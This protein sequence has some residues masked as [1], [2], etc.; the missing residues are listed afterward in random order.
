MLEGGSLFERYSNLVRAGGTNQLQRMPPSIEDGYIRPD[1]RGQAELFAYARAVAAQ[2]RFHALSGQP[3]GDWARLF[4]PLLDAGDRITPQSLA[5]LT[6]RDDLPPQLVLFF[7]FF[8]AFQRIRDDINTLPARHFAHFCDDILGLSRLGPVADR[9]HVIF[10]PAPNAGPLRLEVGTRLDAGQDG[11]GRPLGY[12]LEREMIVNQGK[13]TRV[14]RQVVQRDRQ[15]RLRLFRAE[16]MPKEGWPTFGADPFRTPDAMIETDPGFAIADPVLRLA[17]GR[18]DVSIVARLAAVPDLRDEILSAQVALAFTG[19]EGWLAPESAAVSVIITIAGPELRISAT[20]GAGQPAVIDHDPAIHT[21]PASPASPWPV[22]RCLV[23]SASGRAEVFS[24]L[25]VTNVAISVNVAGV[26]DLIVQNDQRVLAAGGPLQL[27]T[28]RPKI[29]ST[30][31]VGSTEVFAKRLTRLTLNFDWKSLPDS[32]LQHYNEYFDIH[33]AVLTALLV[34]SFTAVIDILDQRSWAHR[35]TGP[36]EPIH[37]FDGNLAARSETYAEGAFEVAYG[38]QPRVADPDLPRQD[39]Y[40]PFTKRGFMRLQLTGPLNDDIATFGV[41]FAQKVPFNAFG[42]DAFAARYAKAALDLARYDP[43]ALGAGPEPVLP[44][45]PYTP[46]I[47]NLRL[48]Y[49]AQ[50]EFA[51]SDVHALGRVLTLGAFGYTTAGPQVAARLSSTP[52]PSATMLLGLEGF[53]APGTISVLFQLDESSVQVAD[54]PAPADIRWSYLSGDRWVS[55]PPSAVAADETRG[56]Q[57]PGIVAVAVGADASTQHSAMPSGLT[58]LRA[59]LAK[60]PLAVARTQALHGQAATALFDPGA[61]HLDDYADHLAAGLAPITITR[62]DPRR[63]GIKKVAQPY[64]SFG[65]R[66][67]ESDRAFFV[68]S[69]ERIRH[70]SRAVTVWDFEHNVLQRFEQIF[71][72]RCLPNTGDDTAPAVGEVALVIVPKLNASQTANQLEPRASETLME[73]IGTFL[74]DGLATPFAAVR[75]I[76]PVYERVL[77]DAAVAFRKGFDPGFYAEQLNIDLQRVLSPWAFEEGRDIAFGTRIYRSELLKYVEDRPYVDYVT[78]FDLY[79]AFNGPPRQGIGFMEIG[80]DFV[81]GADP[82]PAVKTMTVGLD[83]IVGR[84]VETAPSTR[85][86]AILVSHPA[87]RIT[88]IF[89][90]SDESTGDMTFGI[91][92][93]IVGLDFDIAGPL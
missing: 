65:G 38:T 83:F 21:G 10:T 42:H 48:D 72:V 41:P 92:F 32:L 87:H 79:H 68:R 63:N 55:L 14:A 64:A 20:L 77:V 15:G 1:E 7:A 33:D 61:G 26:T 59:D 34:P 22:L 40:G 37:L 9:V 85:S 81:I 19:A 57:V 86:D 75:A 69:V 4:D 88:P 74:Q 66:P 80:L 78:R 62:L 70:R 23:R 89:P 43:A 53:A 36:T 28:S 17:E 8:E 24:K 45:E 84:P 6:V 56:F 71:K 67:A 76:H 49:A 35:L 54:P 51:P 58:W 31:Y 82:Q 30:F 12:R 52:D 50:S 13:I 18:R 90:G 5:A 39:R 91:G 46:E 2:L 11:M 93:M 73:E 25:V 3:A 60:P 47:E 29:G 27:F 44:K 16:D